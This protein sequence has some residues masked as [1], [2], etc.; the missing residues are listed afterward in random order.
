MTNSL[1]PFGEIFWARAETLL[2]LERHRRARWREPGRGEWF[3]HT[4]WV[5]S[6][7]LIVIRA[8]RVSS[9][10]VFKARIP[11]IDSAR[12]ICVLWLTSLTASVDASDC[13]LCTRRTRSLPASQLQPRYWGEA[14]R[15]GWKIITQVA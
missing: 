1:L 5:L 15:G 2:V 8:P 4:T 10:L 14:V 7:E 3:T 6:V 9:V 11:V 13:L 12:L